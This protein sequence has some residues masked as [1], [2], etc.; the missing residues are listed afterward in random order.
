M[1]VRQIL[2]FMDLHSEP[3]MPIKYNEANRKYRRMM[4]QVEAIRNKQDRMR[5]RM[6]K[7]QDDAEQNYLRS[8][9]HEL[10]KKHDKLMAE[11]DPLQTN[12]LE[13]QNG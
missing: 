4:G 10:Q 6:Q 5:L 7:S 12:I 3:D 11:I 1:V 9:I 8:E 2:T 13:S